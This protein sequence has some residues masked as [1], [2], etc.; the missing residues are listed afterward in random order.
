MCTQGELKGTQYFLLHVIR[1]PGSTEPTHY[2]HVCHLRQMSHYPKQI[3]D[4]FIDFYWNQ[5]TEV[6]VST[7]NFK[8]LLEG[9]RIGKIVSLGIPPHPPKK[10]SVWCGKKDSA[11][12]SW[13]LTLLTIKRKWK[14]FWG[15]IRLTVPTPILNCT[16]NHLA[17]PVKEQLHLA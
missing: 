13:E 4:L 3:K 12:M 14:S 2:I 8:G 9:C 5:S 15:A 7:L 10:K 17:V 6:V 16:G 11:E 1:F